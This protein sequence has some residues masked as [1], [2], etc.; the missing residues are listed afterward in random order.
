MFL[1]M[2][3]SGCKSTCNAH[4]RDFAA[5][6]GASHR[7]AARREYHAIPETA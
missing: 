3:S 1:P 7:D 2:N 4:W 6:A 5:V